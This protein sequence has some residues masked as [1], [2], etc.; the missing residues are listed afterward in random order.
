LKLKELCDALEKGRAAQQIIDAA[1]RAVEAWL[2]ALA[3][4]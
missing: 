3:E 1:K 2:K 4:P